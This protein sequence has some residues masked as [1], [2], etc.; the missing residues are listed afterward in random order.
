MN[1]LIRL[2]MEIIE[3]VYERENHERE[4]LQTAPKAPVAKQNE[5][6]R[7]PH[8]SQQR[9]DTATQQDVRKALQDV[10]IQ[11]QA[12]AQPP[13][14]PQP[15]RRPKAPKRVSEEQVE[16]LD[17]HIAQ[18]EAYQAGLER[19]AQSM[20]DHTREHLGHPEET[21]DLEFA[22]FVIPGNS[23]IEQM[24][25]AGVILGPCKAQHAR[26]LL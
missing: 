3:A 5:G 16:S 23:P 7:Q 1:I 13:L 19:R 10:F 14:A 24:I 21:R 18:Q 15:Q 8:P 11:L 12:G 9:A 20:D 6:A 26:R 25:L 17:E 4:R 22:K 2:I